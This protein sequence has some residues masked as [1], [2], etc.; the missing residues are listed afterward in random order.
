[1]TVAQVY[2][3]GL[4]LIQQPVIDNKDF[5]QFA[6]DW[7]NVALADAFEVENSIRQ[8]DGE[9]PLSEPP[10]LAQLSDEVPYNWKITRLAFPKKIASLA[11]YDE[12]N[13]GAANFT[14]EYYSALNDAA[15][16]I[17]T[18]V[19]DVYGEEQRGDI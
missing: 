7:I 6:V 10:E 16:L 13:D 4:S 3:A 8:Y 19:S 11:L 2:K 14:S 17:P 9:T 5:E 15:K 12:D 1:M 18:V